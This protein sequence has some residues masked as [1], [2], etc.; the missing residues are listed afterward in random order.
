MAALIRYEKCGVCLDKIIF[1][2]FTNAAGYHPGLVKPST[3][4]TNVS[5]FQYII[6]IVLLCFNCYMFADKK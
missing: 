4:D 1:L 2:L 3:A 6:I 5:T